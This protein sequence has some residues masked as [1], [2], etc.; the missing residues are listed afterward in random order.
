MTLTGDITCGCLSILSAA[1]PL[2]SV[3]HTGLQ[4]SYMLLIISIKIVFHGDL[5]VDTPEGIISYNI[6]LFL[7]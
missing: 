3:Q 4:P 5:L 2:S 7:A 1:R 6:Y